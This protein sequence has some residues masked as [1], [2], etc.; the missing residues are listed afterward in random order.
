NIKLNETRINAWQNID[1]KPGDRL[2]IAPPQHGLRTYIA[3]TGGF[4]A[5]SNTGAES[6]HWQQN[7][8]LNLDKHNQIF[9][10]ENCFKRLTSDAT[11]ARFIPNYDAPLTLQLIPA[12]QYEQFSE[13]AINTLLTQKYT[14]SPMSNRMGYRLQ[15]EPIT[16]CEEALLSEGI[17]Y[18]SVQ[19]PPNGQPIVLLKDRQTIGGYPKLGCISQQDCFK[20]GQ[21]RPGQ[22]ITFTLKTAEHCLQQLRTFYQFFSATN[23]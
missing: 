13:Q 5:V 1:I 3:V 11:P 8:D 15:G 21:R 18:G 14:I 6:S 19:I 2:A 7:R 23:S 12:Y 16:F 22:E 17:A 20:L 10:D 9:Y 4:K